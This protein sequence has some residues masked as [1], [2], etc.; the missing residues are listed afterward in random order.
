V[1]DAPEPTSPP[2]EPRPSRIAL[3]SE[4]R[5]PLIDDMKPSAGGVVIVLLLVA[6]QQGAWV[7][8]PAVFGELMDR[9]IDE[10]RTPLDLLTAMPLW[11]I[12][13]LVNTVAGGARRI[14][15]E[16]VYGNMYARLA[17]R[18]AERARA[19]G[20][21]PTQTAA[22]SE[23]A[24]DFVG[25]FEDRLPEAITDAVSLIGAMA[26]LFSYDWRIAAACLGVIGPLFFVGRAYDRNVA[27]LT[28]ELHALREQNVKRFEEGDPQ[29]VLTHFQRVANLK[30]RIGTWSAGNFGVVRGSLLVVFV[31][32]LYVAI[33]VDD[34]TVGRVYSIVTYLWTFVT[35]IETLPELLENLTAVR[36]I[37]ERLS[38]RKP[39]EVS[40]IPGASDDDE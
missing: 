3:P 6:L 22:L 20:T 18:L 19:D 12:V 11:A 17:Q 15:S 14:A 39:L 4:S 8:E 21:P 13:F 36:D 9:V 2:E 16:R 34:M 33:D 28:T 40:A 24:R 30:R 35:A 7:Y 1:T 23:L 37:T 29:A 26:A 27:Q 5:R 25:F 38:G 10:A 31:V 32:V